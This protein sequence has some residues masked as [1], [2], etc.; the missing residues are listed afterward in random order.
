MAISKTKKTPNSA[1]KLTLIN[2]PKGE[3]FPWIVQLLSEDFMQVTSMRYKYET[4]T[5]AMTVARKLVSQGY[6]V[7]VLFEHAYCIS[8]TDRRKS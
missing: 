6:N 1:T 5:R 3:L 7:E 4:K 8:A 2:R